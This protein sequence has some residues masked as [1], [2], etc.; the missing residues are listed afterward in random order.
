[1]IVRVR[2]VWLEY[3]AM[4]DWISWTP[5]FGFVIVWNPNAKIPIFGWSLKNTCPIDPRFAPSPP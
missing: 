3:G 4:I 2:T 1:L 5:D